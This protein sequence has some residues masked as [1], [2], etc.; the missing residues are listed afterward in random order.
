M[1]TVIFDV[2]GVL[3][4]S[5]A[6]AAQVEKDYFKTLG[7]EVAQE[8]FPPLVGSSQVGSLL[9]LAKNH[10]IE[11]NTDEALSYF[12]TNYEKLIKQ[13]SFAFDR[14]KSLILDFKKIGVKVAVASSALKAKVMLNLSALDLPLSTFDLIVTGEDIC[15]NK[16][17]PDIYQ[18]AAIK[19]GVEPSS[20]LVFEDSLLG[21][22]SAKKAGMT[23]VG[24]TTS[25]NAE[26]IAT[27]GANYIISELS[28]I[29]YF[30]TMEQL[31][32]F[33]QGEESKVPPVK[34]GANYIKVG[35]SPFPKEFTIKRM[36]EMARKTRENAYAPFSGFKVGAALLSAKTGR[37]YTGCNVENSSYGATI[38]AERNAVLNAIANEGVIGIET[39]VVVTSSNPPYPPCAQCLQVLAE[40]TKSEAEVILVDLEGNRTTYSFNSLLPLPFLF[41]KV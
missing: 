33:L 2:D 5:E 20:C 39:L 14:A 22:A 17:N 30:E 37:I 15:R 4:D 7:V 13:D 11:I 12:F 31:K 28:A 1:N 9:T 27:S 41:S 24:L 23:V 29:P 21:I 35:K 19:L 16:P 26:V 25:E 8:E 40:F 3:V 18:L 38:C 6:I 32:L 36:I 34:Y 10:K